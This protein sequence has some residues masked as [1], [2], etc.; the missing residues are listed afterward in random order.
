MK[1]K[2]FNVDIDEDKLKRFQKIAKAQNSTSTQM[3]RIWIDEFLAK[4][5]N[6]YELI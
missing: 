6:K 4:N 1:K 3:V 5:A 2:R